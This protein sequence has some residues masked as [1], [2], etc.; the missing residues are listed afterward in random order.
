MPFDDL[1]SEQA[2]RALCCPLNQDAIGTD[3]K[4]WGAKV[5]WPLIV[6]NGD[7]VV[8]LFKTLPLCPFVRTASLLFLTYWLLIW[9][10]A[11]S[12]R[13]CCYGWCW[14]WV[15]SVFCSWQIV[16]IQRKKPSISP[17]ETMFYHCFLHPLDFCQE[18]AIDRRRCVPEGPPGSSNID[19]LH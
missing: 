10:I 13:K 11:V 19:H 18:S 16:G 6:K 17:R 2:N 7:A 12:G 5:S 8:E 4:P 9:M 1:L 15:C 3:Q 14:D